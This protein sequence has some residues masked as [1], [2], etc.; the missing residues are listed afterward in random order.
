MF[1][2]VINPLSEKSSSLLIEYNKIFLSFDCYGML[3]L[4]A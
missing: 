1:G 3:L 4:M 2:I